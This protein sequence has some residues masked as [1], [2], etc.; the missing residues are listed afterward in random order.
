MRSVTEHGFDTAEGLPEPLPEGERL[1]WQGR[2]SLRGL[3]LHAL[4]ARKVGIYF[5]LL[6]AWQFIATRADGLPA[7]QTVAAAA[8]PLLL[9]ALCVGILALIAYASHRTTRYVITSR[10]VVMRIGITLPVTLNLP[11]ARLQS[12]DLRLRGDGSGDL[13]LTTGHDDRVAWALLWPHARAWRLRQPQPML[14]DIE[15]AAAVGEILAAAMSAVA[16]GAAADLAPAVRASGDR[17]AVPGHPSHAA[18][19]RPSVA[20]PLAADGHA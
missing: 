6:S 7:G 8:W 5:A 20:N 12:A 15:D 3:V 19:R 4:H 1:L 2:P 16:T 9:G 13:V 14:R 10:R 11:F 18:V 17:A